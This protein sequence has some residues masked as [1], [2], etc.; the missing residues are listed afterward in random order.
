M[1][2]DHDKIIQYTSR[3]AC[4]RNKGLRHRAVAIFLHNSKD[5][6]LLQKRNHKLF[7]DLWDLA[8]ATHPLH[9]GGRDETYEESGTR[10]L[11]TEWGIASRLHRV[12]AFTYFEP[13]KDRCENEYCVVLAG[14]YD[15]KL[16]PN[17]H[18]IYEFRWVTWAQLVDELDQRPKGFTP[19]LK[20]AVELLN[21]KGMDP[22]RTLA[23]RSF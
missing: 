11:K 19:W 3:S 17:P 22:I 15:G 4:H 1:V 21:R 13:Y 12:L 18:H 8:G 23:D 5:E 2:D 9:L 10:C 7:D 6:I 14:K 20:I 16:N